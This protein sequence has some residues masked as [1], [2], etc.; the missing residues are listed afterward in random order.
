MN[1]WVTRILIGLLLLAGAGLGLR[2][3]RQFTRVQQ[4]QVGH[5][6]LQLGT[7]NRI[8]LTNPASSKVEF[9][10]RCYVNTH[11]EGP[12]APTE[13]IVLQP[14]ETREFDVH[15]E[16]TPAKLP[17]AIANKS[18]TAVWQGPFG[19]ERRAWWAHWQY[20]RP[21]RKIEL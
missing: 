13:K 17:V 9:L 12:V 16:L 7:V 8:T 11:E 3:A 4:V 18:C 15:P 2:W 6:P 1:S 20:F 14:Q 10:L 21:T 5:T 19:L